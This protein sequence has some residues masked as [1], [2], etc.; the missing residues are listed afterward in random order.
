MILR[1]GSFL[2]CT[3]YIGKLSEMQLAF[4]ICGM[5]RFSNDSAH[6]AIDLASDL[7]KSGLFVMDLEW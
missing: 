5:Q 3:I 1:A 4:D 2:E 6:W 7:G